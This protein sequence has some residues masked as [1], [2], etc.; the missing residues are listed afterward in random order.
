[1]DL[2]RLRAGEWIV[3]L[4]GA[5]LLV[6]LFLPWYE[7]TLY[8][9]YRGCP[10]RKL[11]AWEALAVNDVIL[12]AIAGAAIAVFVAALSQ[13]VP[14]VP[15]ALEAM[16]TLLGFVA[17]VLVLVRVVWLPDVADGRE[18]GLYVGLAGALGVAAGGWLGLRDERTHA[19]PRP[20]PDPLPAPRP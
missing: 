13:R 18:W 5:V 2:R 10:P 15:I 12:A 16:V 19:P 4:S 17:V 11:M 20:E 6:S 8:C 7:Q 1:M 14:A 3:A 9:G